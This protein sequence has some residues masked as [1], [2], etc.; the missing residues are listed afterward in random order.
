MTRPLL[1]L[2][3][4]VFFS[5]IKA[6]C[7]TILTDEPVEVCSS[8]GTT[9]NIEVTGT[10]LTAQWS[11]TIGLDNPNILN[12][13]FIT[14]IDTTYLLTITGLDEETKDTCEIQQLIEL[15]I[16]IFDLT[17]SQDTVDLPCGD[18]IRLSAAVVPGGSY[19]I[20]EW[21]TTDGHFTQGNQTLGPLIDAV[22]QYNVNVIGN[23]GR[24]VC[25][26]KDSL[27]VVLRRDNSLSIETAESLNCSQ[28]SVALTV[29]NQ[30]NPTSYLYNWTSP[31]G[32][33]IANTDQFT[34]V[35]NRPGFY[36]VSRTNLFGDCKEEA[37]IEVE[38]ARELNDF[39]LDLIQPS[40]QISSG[41]IE[42]NNLR[43]GQAPFQYSIDNGNTYQS[44]TV[45]NE[46]AETD[47]SVLV[48]DAN[49][50]ELTKSVN[51]IPFKSFDLSLIPF[52]EVEK[53]TAFQFPLI[54]SDNEATVES[55][56]WWPNVGLSCTDCAQPILTEF[57]NRHY[58]ITAIDDKGCEKKAK[59][60][61]A[62]RQPNLFYSPTIFSPNGDGQNDEFAILLNT[63]FVK[64]LKN[65]TIFDRYGNLIFQ[66]LPI[67]A[68]TEGGAWNGR[69]RGKEMPIGTYL[70][71]GTLELLDG[72]LEHISGTLNLVR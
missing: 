37:T 39:S 21:E 62:I 57:K 2:C 46:L 34:T 38:K 8:G 28:N 33:F 17:V 18:T 13:T 24:I 16:A 5:E 70:Y 7:P 12:P 68:L 60:E 51:F 9:V 30:A 71:S 61:I 25:R 50:C 44:S 59:I 72:E 40:C 1:L 58:E 4:V 41:T 49:G 32:Q 65:I 26:D 48:K 19:F 55:I 35:V 15:K 56:E 54:I 14:P 31:N 63:K 52:Q 27:Q 53:G 6:Q 3:L 47:Y 43:G 20:T 67:N 22:G 45:F 11:P 10:V 36:E 42:V 69:Y 66:R 64:G 23:L 29:A